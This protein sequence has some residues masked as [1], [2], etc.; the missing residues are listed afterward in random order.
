MTA[1]NSMNQTTGE[2]CQVC[3]A[4]MAA[5]FTAR[6]M[7][8]HDVRYFAC[9]RC[10]YLRTESPYWLAEAYRDPISPADTGL[11]ARNLQISR[12]LACVLFEFFDH[13]ARYLDSAGGTGLLTRLMRD[14]G[15]DF[16]W[17]DA[18]STN[19][20]ACGFEAPAAGAERPFE[21]VTAFEALEHMSDPMDF[22]SSAIGRSASRTLIFTTELFTAPLPPPDWWY[23]SLPTG[24]HI[25][26]F[27]PA[28]LEAMAGRLGL[29]VLSS[30]GLHMLTARDIGPRAYRR[31]LRKAEKL[32]PRVTR[33]MRSLTAAD[34]Q[35]MLS[36]LAGGPPPEH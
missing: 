33:Q 22:V 3:G 25:G 6:L 34:N 8:A 18:H 4:A 14:I 27:T 16:Y 15:F 11:V 9:P 21:A 36:R 24:Q 13:G 5:A 28:T 20:H 17:E 7:A 12:L 32:F 19:Q 31:T 30:Q 2:Q 23:L 35:L 1:G 10:Q 29:T 26:F